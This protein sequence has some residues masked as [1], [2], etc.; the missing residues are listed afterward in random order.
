[1]G[2]GAC[3]Q[4]VSLHIGQQWSRPGLDRT[5]QVTCRDGAGGDSEKGFGGWEGVFSGL[6]GLM[7]AVAGCSPQ[8]C[9]GLKTKEEPLLGWGGAGWERVLLGE[10]GLAR[11][12]VHPFWEAGLR[13]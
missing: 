5:V 7:E 2:Q 12:G 9:H 10:C 11:Q 13:T 8:Q 1:M 3:C 4:R 6:V